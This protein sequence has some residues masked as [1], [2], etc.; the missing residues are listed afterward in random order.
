MHTFLKP[1]HILRCLP[2]PGFK[3]MKGRTSSR[4]RSADSATHGGAAA[5]PKKVESWEEYAHPQFRRGRRDL[6]V[7]IK[8]RKD[9]GRLKRQRGMTTTYA[10]LFIDTSQ[11][12]HCSMMFE[13][14]GFVPH[15]AN[16]LFAKRICFLALYAYFVCIFR[17]HSTKR[18][19]SVEIGET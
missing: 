19:R 4:S 6:L 16:P 15:P 12:L 18:W 14:S 10:L 9:C 5:T 2:Y 3:K 11:N 8:R 1:S 13:F 17:M 7:G